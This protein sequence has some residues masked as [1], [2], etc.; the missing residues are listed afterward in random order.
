MAFVSASAVPV[1]LPIVTW[2]QRESEIV[3]RDFNAVA[4]GSSSVSKEDFSKLLELHLVRQPTPAEVAS[5][6]R[7]FGETGSQ[8]ADWLQWAHPAQPKQPYVWNL[9]LY[10]YGSSGMGYEL[11]QKH[12]VELQGYVADVT[13]ELQKKGMIVGRRCT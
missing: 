1:T 11:N 9:G 13:T 5:V 3:T 10:N 12:F 6:T 8:L 2:S 7:H 4:A